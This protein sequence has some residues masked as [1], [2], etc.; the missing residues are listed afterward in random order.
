M[1]SRTPT[2]VFDRGKNSGNP[3][4]RFYNVYLGLKTTSIP[5]YAVTQR[6]E[7]KGVKLSESL[8]EFEIRL[9]ESD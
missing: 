8:S 7:F 6:Q 3:I 4:C 9:N 2:K 1:S 5:V